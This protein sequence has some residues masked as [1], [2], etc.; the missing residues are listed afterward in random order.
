[1]L[2]DTS[3]RSAS[4][5]GLTWSE[6]SHD[7]GLAVEDYRINMAIQGGT[8]SVVASGI[9]TTSYVVSG[10]VLGTTYEWTIEARN[11]DGFSLESSSITILHAI[12]PEKPTAPTTSNSG[13]NVIIS[14]SA[15]VDNGSSITSYTILI[16][17]GD[18]VTYTEDTVNCDGTE[19]SI[20][21]S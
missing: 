8:Y 4:T 7:G 19:S 20:I 9:A 15:P 12:P 14:W 16:R 1:M 13:V 6:G 11:S 10:L 5:I 21:L 17:E 2:E 3:E 18:G